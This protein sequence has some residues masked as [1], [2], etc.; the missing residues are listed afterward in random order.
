MEALT[1][2]FNFLELITPYVE[3]IILF[4]IPIYMVLGGVF[5]NL[6]LLFLDFLSDESIV[7]PLIIMGVFIVLGILGGIMGKSPEEKRDKS[8]YSP[9]ARKEP[10]SAYDF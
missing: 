1:G 4:V 5:A 9:S 10:E 7:V 8:S 6:G 2:L 3:K